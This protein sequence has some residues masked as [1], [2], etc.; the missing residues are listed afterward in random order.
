MRQAESE[1]GDCKAWSLGRLSCSKRAGLAVPHRPVTQQALPLAGGVQYRVGVGGRKRVAVRWG[2]RESHGWFAQGC[3]S[4]KSAPTFTRR[5]V[6]CLYSQGWLRAPRRSPHG[7]HCSAAATLKSV[8][9][10]LHGAPNSH[11]TGPSTQGRPL[12]IPANSQPDSLPRPLQPGTGLGFP[13]VFLPLLSEGRPPESLETGL[14]VLLCIPSA[15]ALALTPATFLV[16][17]TREP[18][19]PRGQEACL[20]LCLSARLS[21]Q[22]R[23]TVS[24]VT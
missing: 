3:A 22:H 15:R 17:V 18:R 16:S 5:L 21:A 7:A 10:V 6:S 23:E 20:L 9:I 4:S 12:R 8:G 13:G 24:R 2:R 11:L 14:G 19:A 1:D